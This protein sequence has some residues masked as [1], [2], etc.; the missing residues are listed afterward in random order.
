MSKKLICGVDLGGTKLSAGLF[1]QDGT[2]VG[3]ETVYDHRDEQWDEILIIIADLVKR[4][5]RSCSVEPDDILGIGVAL[6]GHI[7]F[8]KGVIVTVSNFVHNIYDY[9]FVDKLSVLLPGMRIILDNDAN[10]Q[11]FGEFKFGAGRGYHDLV[12]VTVS[13]G[14]GGGIIVN[15]KMLRGKVGT[16]GEVGHTIIDIDSDV[17]CTCGNY[18]CAMALASGLFFPELYR[19]Q[20]RKGLKSTIGIT[21][22]SADKMDGQSIEEG[23]KKG[24]PICRVIVED[25]ADVV[26]STLYNIYKTLD[27][28]LVILG[29]GLMSFGEDYMNRIQHRFLSHTYEMMAEEMEIKLAE[30]GRDAGLIGAAALVLE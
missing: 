24:D 14:I 4:V 15:D 8:K 16:A 30:T 3:K 6:A 17:K 23:M 22:A 28:E 7:H 26:G 25:S 9:P 10:A 27:P 2:L 1:R 21:E 19:R 18:G 20:L 29:G 13:T 12:F 11:A 5:M